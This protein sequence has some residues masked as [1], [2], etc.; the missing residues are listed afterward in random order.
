MI[1]CR[2][3]RVYVDMSV[4]SFDVFDGSNPISVTIYTISD[5]SPISTNIIFDGPF[6]STNKGRGNKLF[7]HNTSLLKNEDTIVSIKMVTC[8]TKFC[9]QV[10]AMCKIGSLLLLC[11]RMCLCSLGKRNLKTKINWRRP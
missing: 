1:Y 8:L 9:N 3:D 5:G 6:Q 7:K 11:G 4:F 2:M 10:S